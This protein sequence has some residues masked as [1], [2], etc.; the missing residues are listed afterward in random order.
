MA[1]KFGL[2]RRLEVLL[3]H[4]SLAIPSQVGGMLAAE[5]SRGRERTGSSSLA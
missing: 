2:R 4:S 5:V 3:K 1:R